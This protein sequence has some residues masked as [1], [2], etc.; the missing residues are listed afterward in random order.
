MV[1]QLLNN[2]QLDVGELGGY[3]AWSESHYLKK[4]VGVEALFEV[5]EAVEDLDCALGIANVEDLVNTGLFLDL[6]DGSWCII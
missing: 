2:A 6:C 4:V 1:F 3:E 5:R